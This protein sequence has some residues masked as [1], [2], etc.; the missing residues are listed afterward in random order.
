MKTLALVDGNYCVIRASCS[1]SGLRTANGECTDGIH[2]FLHHLWKATQ[3]C[4]QIVVVFDKGHNVKRTSIYP[5]YKVRD[6]KPVDELTEIELMMLDARK[7]AFEYVPQILK[8]LGIPVVSIGGHEADDIIFFLAKYLKNNYAVSV[9]SDDSDYIQMLKH[10]IDIVRPIKGDKLT[11]NNYT[12]IFPY[13]LKYF[14]LFKSMVGDSADNI[15]GV[16]KI[17]KVTAGKI[18]QY[19]IDNN[20]ENPIIGLHEWSKLADKVVNRNLREGIPIVKR[21]LKL[22][23]IEYMSEFEDLYIKT[24]EDILKTVKAD[25]NLV[26]EFFTRFEL[27]S[28]ASWLAFAKEREI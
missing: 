26:K 6:L 4:S 10:G 18:I 11:P 27:N 9:I 23:D 22:V 21:N 3:F 5:E 1:K 19:I 17:G 7:L 20:I 14:T 13:P 2:V 15:Q 25:C 16:N 8:A 12:E 24:Y 28:H